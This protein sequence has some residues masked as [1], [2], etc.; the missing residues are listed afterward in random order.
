LSNARTHTQ[1]R[2]QTPMDVEVMPLMLDED[3]K[4]VREWLLLVVLAVNSVAR[5]LLVMIGD[6]D[7]ET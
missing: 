1:E 5:E 7:Y 2:A 6:Y 3:V 4:D